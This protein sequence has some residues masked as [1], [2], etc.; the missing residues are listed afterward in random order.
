MSTSAFNW[1]FIEQ[2]A[3]L[4]GFGLSLG[5]SVLY[6]SLVILLP[7]SALLMY[8]SDMSLAEYWAAI[9]H[10]RV[11]ASYKTTVG[12]ALISTLFISLIGLLLAWVLSRYEFVGRRIVDGLIDLPFALPTA[13]A[14]LTL[15]TLFAP[16][17][18]LGH[19][20]DALGI[21]IAFAWP[22]I[23]LAMSFTSLPFIVRS[24]QPLI[25]NIDNSLDEAAETLGAQPWQ[26]FYYVILPLLL[27]GLVTG[28]S[29]AFIR[30]LGEFGAVIFIAGNT[31]YQTEVSSLMIFVRLAEYDYASA[32]AIASVVLA[33]SLLLL[34]GLQIVQNRLFDKKH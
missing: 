19:Y 1:R 24:V 34:F 14:G 11:I 7:L 15:A 16:N 31:P 18:W 20:F 12:A 26:R 5:V 10:P 4:P 21:K 2:K 29:Q 13:V 27:P 3:V 22:G 25:E 9:S 6:I 32:A 28:A 33:T 17:G 30:C 23:V 8:V